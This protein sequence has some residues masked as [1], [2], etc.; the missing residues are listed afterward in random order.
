MVSP[1]H[2]KRTTNLHAPIESFHLHKTG[3]TLHLSPSE[4][5]KN[6]RF[7]E[8]EDSNIHLCRLYH[9]FPKFYMYNNFE[10][11]YEIQCKTSLLEL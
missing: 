8:S 10:S 5:P 7:H 1:T 9:F 4:A 11:P 3:A 2:T 6:S